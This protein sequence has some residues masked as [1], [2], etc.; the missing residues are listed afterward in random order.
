VNRGYQGGA[1]LTAGGTSELYADDEVLILHQKR[2][3]VIFIVNMFFL[4]FIFQ[5]AP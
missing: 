3:L 1:A 5:L 4:K 2:C